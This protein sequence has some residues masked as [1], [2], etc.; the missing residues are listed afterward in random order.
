VPQRILDGPQ[1]VRVA[2]GER[3]GSVAE[4]VVGD[5]G[6][7][8]A[9][10]PQMAIHREAHAAPRDPLSSGAVTDGSEERVPCSSAITLARTSR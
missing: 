2:L 4:G 9:G 3:G 7:L 10:L 1:V 8:Q 6:A 5:A